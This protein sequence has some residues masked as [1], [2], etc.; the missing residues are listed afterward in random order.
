M[1]K[2]KSDKDR[3][4]I[5]QNRLDILLENNRIKYNE[6]KIDL[7]PCLV[8]SKF[9]T[10]NNYL[11]DRCKYFSESEDFFYVKVFLDSGKFL[12]GHQFSVQKNNQANFENVEVVNTQTAFLLAELSEQTHVV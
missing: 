6:K 11:W 9:T 7:R 10:Q 8:K 2:L 1:L 5:I 4:L 12:I 3:E